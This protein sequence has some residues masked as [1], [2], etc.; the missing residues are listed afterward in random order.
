MTLQSSGGTAKAASA[1]C[2]EALRIVGG[3]VPFAVEAADPF[4][5]VRG[6]DLNH[7]HRA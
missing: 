6:K 5:H 1:A 4:A 3:F 2:A 7:P